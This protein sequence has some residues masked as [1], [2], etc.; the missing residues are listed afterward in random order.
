M[1]RQLGNPVS[2]RDASQLAPLV[3]EGGGFAISKTGGSMM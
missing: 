1:F 2:F 3:Y